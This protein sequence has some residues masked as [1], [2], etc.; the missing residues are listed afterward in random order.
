MHAGGGGRAPDGGLARGGP[1]AAL[2]RT[3]IALGQTLGLRTVV[4][5]VEDMAQ[6]DQL[7]L[8]GCQLGQGYLFARPMPADETCRWLADAQP[9]VLR[10]V[11]A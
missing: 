10:Q 2:A 3:I 1:D 9:L 11:A 5:G 7:R 6:R 8:L 4:E